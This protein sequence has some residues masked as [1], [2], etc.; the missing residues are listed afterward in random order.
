M[1][2]SRKR[3]T[4]SRDATAL[5]TPAHSRRISCRNVGTRGETGEGAQD[6]AR[7]PTISI[8]SH[9]PLPPNPAPHHRQSPALS[10]RP[11][12][13]SSRAYGHHRQK[14][15][16]NGMTPQLKMAIRYAP[17]TPPRRSLIDPPAESHSVEIATTRRRPPLRGA[18]V[19]KISFLL[20][21]KW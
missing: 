7:R 18:P 12:E 21:L 3:T 6:V 19:E 15:R 9:P 13:L 11:R 16:L 1:Y 5:P 20:Q 14:L 8:L 4:V 17:A 10:I 2:G